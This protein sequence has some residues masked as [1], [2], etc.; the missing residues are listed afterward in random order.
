M[1][2]KLSKRLETIISFVGKDSYPADIG[3]DH[4][5]V[6]IELISRGI[7]KRA[8]AVENKIGP[9]QRM[10]NAIEEAGYE[11]EILCSLGDGIASIPSEVNE[12]ILAGMGGELIASILLSHPEK[13]VKV[14]YLVIDAHREYPFLLEKLGNLGFLAI[15]DSFFYDKGKP[16]CVYRFKNV[17]H[18]FEYSPLELYFGPIEITRK[19]E[20]WRIYF[21][22]LLK[23]KKAILAQ[24]NLSISAKEELENEINLIKRCT[25]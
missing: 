14:S 1:A 25:L 21:L 15:D 20:A 7:V 19:S 3:S 24:Q 16:Y 2:S 18:S 13:L 23:T 6:P 22:S 5:L 17:H 10:K 11:N 9:F 8:F 12:V 4:A